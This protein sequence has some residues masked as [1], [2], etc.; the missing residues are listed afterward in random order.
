MEYATE[1]GTDA[2]IHTEFHKVWFR[3]SKFDGGYTAYY[4]FPKAG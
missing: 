4:N 1:M 3:H 2:M